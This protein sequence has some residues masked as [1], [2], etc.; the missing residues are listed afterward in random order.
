MSDLEQ[1]AFDAWETSWVGR[2]IQRITGR[3]T[4]EELPLK[5]ACLRFGI[6]ERSGRRKL[7]KGEWKQTG[8]RT[9]KQGKPSPIV[10]ISERAL[11]SAS[12]P[13]WL[14][15]EM[16]CRKVNTDPRRILQKILV[17]SRGDL[18]VLRTSIRI[19]LEPLSNTNGVSHFLYYL[20]RK[21]GPTKSDFE[22]AL[23]SRI[24]QSLPKNFKPRL[25]LDFR[26][27]WTKSRHAVIKGLLR[28]EWRIDAHPCIAWSVREDHVNL[29]M[30]PSYLGELRSM[31]SV[32]PWALESIVPRSSRFSSRTAYEKII[33]AA[34]PLRD[35]RPVK[36][37]SK[38]RVFSELTT[39]MDSIESGDLLDRANPYRSQIME[40][41]SDLI[42]E[43][44]S[45]NFVRA[46]NYRSQPW[47]PAK[48]TFRNL[49]NRVFMTGK[50]NRH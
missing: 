47:Q 17:G 37:Q 1:S 2:E 28:G 40:H 42:G 48:R 32:P 36:D 34:M 13:R 15:F 38:A 24:N 43:R 11:Q 4:P 27:L 50:S 39:M 20:Q 33:K 49:G 35:G 23:A 29:I 6:S 45:L 8:E 10:Q 26:D 31:D 25:E 18:D 16:A 41:L 12:T 22:K 19:I 9:N 46:W 14:T 44:A 3:R 21:P 30:M 7:T 5:D